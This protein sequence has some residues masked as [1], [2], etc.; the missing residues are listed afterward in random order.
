MSQKPFMLGLLLSGWLVPTY[1]TYTWFLSS[2][3]P[4]NSFPFAEWSGYAFGVACTWL[5]V[6]IIAWTRFAVR[7]FRHN[8]GP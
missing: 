8:Q 7:R 3:D 4:R 5:G 6:V 2:L 1:L